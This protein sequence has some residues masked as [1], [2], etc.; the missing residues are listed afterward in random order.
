MSSI[1]LRSKLKYQN[2]EIIILHCLQKDGRRYECET[3]TFVSSNADVTLPE[4]MCVLH[5]AISVRI[6]KSRLAI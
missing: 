3:T 4:R 5:F 2:I 6:Q 1:F